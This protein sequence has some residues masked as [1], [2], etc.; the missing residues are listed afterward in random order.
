MNEFAKLISYLFHSRTQTH[1][2]H[3]QTDSFAAH[4]ALNGYYDGII[5]LVDGL[6]ESYQGKYGILTGY[7]N[8]NLLEYNNCEE[9]IIYFQSLNSTIEKLRTMIPQDSYIQNQIDTVTELITSTMYKLK[10]LK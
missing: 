2:F 4:M 7:S 6:V 10:F 8:F 1:I 3:L 9:V 5:E